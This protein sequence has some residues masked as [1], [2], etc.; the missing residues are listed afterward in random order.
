MN[1]NESYHK[2][3]GREIKEALEDEGFKS[4]NGSAVGFSKIFKNSERTILFN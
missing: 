4:I 2:M 3:S 1:K